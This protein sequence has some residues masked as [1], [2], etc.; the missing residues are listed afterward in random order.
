MPACIG[1]AKN[2]ADVELLPGSTLVGTPPTRTLML[3]GSARPVRISMPPDV[4]SAVGA[5]PVIWNWSVPGYCG[6][7]PPPG[8]LVGTG[9]R[10]G[11]DVGEAVG[12]L[13]GPVV[14][15]PVG[16]GAGCDDGDGCVP[17]PP[18][19]GSPA[20][21]GVGPAVGVTLDVGVA[22][23]AE[24]GA[25]VGEVDGRAVGADVGAGSGG[26][27]PAR[28]RW[29]PGVMDRYSVAR[30]MRRVRQMSAIEVVWSW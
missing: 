19:A 21:T 24:L 13:V 22:P 2:I 8:A 10:T 17:E 11:V 30:E 6:A 23:R 9:V 3:D 26:E 28:P 1:G 7:L 29:G 14:E 18:G 12:P 15:E 5:N 20:R 25:A 16:C 27:L 4:G